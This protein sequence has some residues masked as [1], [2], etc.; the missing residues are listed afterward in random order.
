[1]LIIKK[2]LFI[3]ITIT[4]VIIS[5]ITCLQCKAFLISEAFHTNPTHP[6]HE[7]IEVIDILEKFG[8]NSFIFSS[9]HTV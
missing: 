7:E 9:M 5:S 2:H 8:A 3:T 6:I 1:M 4:M